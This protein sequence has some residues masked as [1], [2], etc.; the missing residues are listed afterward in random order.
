VAPVHRTADAAADGV[1]VVERPPVEQVDVVAAVHAGPRP[2]RQLFV[3]ALRVE[4]AD[5]DRLGGLAA[6]MEERREERHRRDDAALHPL[7]ELVLAAQ[8]ELG[9]APLVDDA[10]PERD[11]VRAAPRSSAEIARGVDASVRAELEA[12]LVRLHGL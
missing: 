5:A 8:L 1:L 11:D 3:G 10:G 2:E 12:A 6:E 4:V 7:A 9:V